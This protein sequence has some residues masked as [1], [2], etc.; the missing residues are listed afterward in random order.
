MEIKTANLQKYFKPGRGVEV[1]AI[2]GISLEIKKGETVAVTGPSGAGKSTLLHLLGLMDRPSAG[3]ITIDG[4]DIAGLTDAGRAALRKDKTGFL[5]QMH[6]LLPEF[7]VLE[8]VLIPVW[9]KRKTEQGKL[10]SLL[11]D[12]G[13][14]DRIHHLPSELSGGEQQRAA[15]ARALANGPEL[16]LADE[17][18]G[19]L[20]R[21][22]GELV[23]QIIFNE[24]RKSNITLVLVTHND[25]LSRKAGKLLKMRD[26]L[27]Q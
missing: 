24:C 27:L 10:E 18:T 12:L 22:T 21:E 13:L 26:G 6:Y 14:K 2:K 16:L 25:E 11:E 8:N 5:F 20:D 1:K 4:A 9:D 3:S 7:T 15:L 17:P 19:D 23:E